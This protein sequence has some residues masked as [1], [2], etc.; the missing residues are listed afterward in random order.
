M[1][2]SFL[3]RNHE[4]KG[5]RVRPRYGWNENIKFTKI[6]TIQRTLFACWITK[7]TDAH[8]EYVILIALCRQKWLRERA[9]M[10][11]YTYI[12]CYYPPIYA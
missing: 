9:S 8:S 6:R 3:V 7:A 2:R 4:R 10:I 1:Q 5:T 11:R 12:A